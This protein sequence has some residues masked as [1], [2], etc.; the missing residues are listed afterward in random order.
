M[1]ISE[2]KYKN[3]LAVINQ[4]KAQQKELEK[5]KVKES[6]ITLATTLK[7]LKDNNLISPKLYRTLEEIYKWDYAYS[8]NDTP[9]EPYIGF[10]IETKYE[11]ISKWR[12]IGKTMRD[13][14]VSLMAAAGHEVV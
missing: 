3:A 8:I 6:G 13:E 10:F 5:N 1:Y 14:F 11:D 2:R 7:E 4:Y 12:G 9:L